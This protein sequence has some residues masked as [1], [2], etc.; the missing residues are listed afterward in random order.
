MVDWQVTAVTINC[1]SVAEEVTIIVK[2]DWSVKC[3]GFEKYSNSRHARLDLVSRSMVLKRTLDCPGL[4]CKPIA[5]YL[6]KL[7]AEEQLHIGAP[8]ETTGT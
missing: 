5:E 7:Q 8:R 6:Q 1:N 3:T 4:Q 2:S